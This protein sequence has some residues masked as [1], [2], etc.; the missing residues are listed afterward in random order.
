M[1][2]KQLSSV[3]VDQHREGMLKMLSIVRVC[4]IGCVDISRVLDM[5]NDPIFHRTGELVSGL[6]RNKRAYGDVG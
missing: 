1:F 3:S 2:T 4:V 6:N 5:G